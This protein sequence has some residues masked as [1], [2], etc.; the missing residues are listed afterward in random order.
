ME[1]A[2]A[3]AEYAR[4]APSTFAIRGAFMEGQ[5]IS[6]D[7]LRDLVR[8]PPKPVMLAQ[9]AGQ[10]QSPLAVLSGL[11]DSPLRELASLLQSALSELPSLIEARARQLET[12]QGQP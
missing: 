8:L 3:I 5:V 2:K 10:L 11:L 9:L 6:P 7:D 1:A 12:T 4:S